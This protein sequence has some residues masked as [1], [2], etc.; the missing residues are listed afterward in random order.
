MTSKLD[1]RLPK[2]RS[3]DERA[4]EG[5]KRLVY[6]DKLVG[7]SLVRTDSPKV[8]HATLVEKRFPDYSCEVY[9]IFSLFI[10][11]AFVIT[12][13]DSDGLLKELTIFGLSGLILETEVS[14][15]QAKP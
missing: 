13:E 10:F 14:S 8:T 3:L 1:Q 11:S 4:K 12:N 7:V 5:R 6:R 2:S 9:I 15:Q